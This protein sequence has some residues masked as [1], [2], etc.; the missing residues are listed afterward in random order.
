MGGEGGGRKTR[1][2]LIAIVV[3]IVTLLLAAIAY[4]AARWHA[5]TTSLDFSSHTKEHVA[6]DVA[7]VRQEIVSEEAGLDAAADRLES[8]LSS[9]G[10]PPTRMELFRMLRSEASKRGRGAR[11]LENGQ[12]IAWWGEDL[13]ANAARTYQFD[14][15]NLYITRTRTTGPYVIETYQRIPNDL[16]E[17]SAIRPDIHWIDSATFHGGFLRQD[18]GTYR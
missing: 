3:A 1:R 11:I 16:D 18:P 10:A 6:D 9:P 2:S 15:T 12:P 8:Q 17:Q 5:R 7:H 13:R 4:G 14:V